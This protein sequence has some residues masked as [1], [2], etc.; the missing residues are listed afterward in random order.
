MQID[1]KSLYEALA[2]IFECKENI[3]IR[4]NIERRERK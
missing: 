3:I 1:V 4:V 2:K